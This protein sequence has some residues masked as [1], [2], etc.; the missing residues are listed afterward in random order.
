MVGLVARRRFLQLGA[1]G[2]ALTL[3]GVERRSSFANGEKVDLALVLAVD[4][5]YSVDEQEFRQQMVGLGKAF[6]RVEVLHAIKAGDIGKVAVCVFEWSNSTNR[7]V[8]L[9]WT[10]IS[11]GPETITLGKTITQIAR[12]L[13][14]GGT[15]I[16]N[17]MLFGEALLTQ[18]PPAERRVI[19]ISSDGRNN[20]GVSVRQVRS[21]LVEQGIVINGLVI[22]NEFPTLD[23]YFEEEVVGGEGH[24]VIVTESYDDYAEAIYKK[25]LREITGPGVT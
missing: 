21:R 18:A 24:F 11:G 13:A 8:V 16:S 25:L 17:A 10:V 15:S 4:C 2:L 22:R 9:P 6:Q 14:Q 12:V 7:V 19:D 5:S 1:A 20:T 3:P 23:I